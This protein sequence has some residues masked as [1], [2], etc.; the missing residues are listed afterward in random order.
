MA[1]DS[2]LSGEPRPGDEPVDVALRPKHLHEMIGQRMV[3]D[4]LD[5][6]IAAAKGRDEP[7]EHILLDGPPGLGKTTLAIVTAREM[8]G[9]VPRITSG[10]S[11]AKQ[12][13]LMALLTNLETGD[14]LF[15]DE[16][17]RLPTVVE[18]FL[19][20]AM[21]DF[22]VDYTIEGGLSGRVVNFA[23]RRFTLIGA[24]T[25][26]GMLSGAMRDRFGHRF[27]LEF[28]DTTELTTILARS[29]Q[30]LNMPC[31]PLSLETIAS[32]SRGTPRVGNRLLRRVRDFAQVR[33]DGALTKRLV[34]EALDIQQVDTLG[35]DELDRKFL[36]TLNHVYRGGPAGIEAIAATMGEERDTLEDTVE[37]YLLQIGFVIRTRQGRQITQQACD[38]LGIAFHDR[39][40]GTAPDGGATLFA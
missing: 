6:A 31:E 27:H 20:P 18:E 38:H 9:K 16:I 5:I 19:Y 7:L 24:T 33:G 32:R 13:D 2:L 26:A 37:P 1:R 4:K 3:L 15:I 28:Y 30:R 23:L 39:T 34:H 14:V 11:L 8:T 29:A 12:A 25:R 36:H 17:H 40:T 35:L 21:E 10:P 22:R